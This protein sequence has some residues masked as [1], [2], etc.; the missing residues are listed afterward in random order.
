M[1]AFVWFPHFLHWPF[2]PGVFIAILGFLAAFVTFWEPQRGLVKALWTGLFFGLMVGEIWMVSKDRDKHELDEQNARKQ[3]QQQE[4]NLS[5]LMFQSAVQ[6]DQLAGIKRQ[7]REAK[8]DPA[9]MAELRSKAAATQ[10]AANA[11]AAAI[12]PRIVDQ[13]RVQAGIYSTQQ[14][15]LDNRYQMYV[16][17]PDPRRRTPPFDLN[18]EKARFHSEFEINVR[19]LI[20][21]ADSLRQTLLMGAPQGADDAEMEAWFAR[22][23]QGGELTYEDVMKAGRYLQGLAE[24]SAA[25]ATS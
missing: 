8:G 15:D 18:K 4:F 1:G 25:A 14:R 10:K 12:M 6:N 3:A 17:D 16:T 5:L 19:P 9:Q 22:A 20:G 24:R 21:M 11:T 7:M 23:S 13:I 2:S